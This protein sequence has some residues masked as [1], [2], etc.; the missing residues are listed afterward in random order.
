MSLLTW[1]SNIF[2]KS[3]TKRINLLASLH[4]T[5]VHYWL[6]WF[7]YHFAKSR[8]NLVLV[9]NGFFAGHLANKLAS[10]NLRRTV[11]T[12]MKISIYSLANLL[13]STVVILGYHFAKSRRLIL[14]ALVISGVFVGN[15]ANK[16]PLFYLRRTVCTPME[17]PICSLV[18]L[19]TS[20]TVILRSAWTS[21]TIW[22][23]SP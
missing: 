8:L 12:P 19:V 6:D 13:T 5:F 15:L 7:W 4:S 11:C 22:R 9:I 3:E 17:I 14:L 20:T 18:N 23:S 1:S 21:V 16:L 2:I 10:F